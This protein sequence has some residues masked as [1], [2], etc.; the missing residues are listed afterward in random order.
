M[1]HPIVDG[2]AFC[3]PSLRNSAG[4]EGPEELRRLLQQAMGT[5]YQRAWRAA[6]R[7][8]GDT[9]ALMDL[10]RWWSL[11]SLK[12]SDFHAASHGR[13]EWTSGKDTLVKQFMAPSIAEMSYS[14][15]QLVAEMDY[16]GVQTAVLSRNPYL[17][18]GNDFLTN[19]VHRY[20]DRLL[21]LAHVREWL[22][23][24]ELDT[25]IAT[26]QQAVKQQGMSGIHFFPSSM[27]LYGQDGPWDREELLP[28]WDAVAELK[29]PV[30]LTL[31]PGGE[32]RRVSYFEELK[33]LV[34]WI[35][36]YPDVP[37]V[38]THGLNWRLFMTDD[39]IDLPEE[40]WLP[41]E[42][43]N[44]HLQLMFPIALGGVWEYPMAEVRPTIE[45]CVRRIGADR[46]MWGSAMP[47]VMRY[48]TYKQCI[49]FI[50]RYLDDLGQNEL[51]GI[52]GGTCAK[53]LGISPVQPEL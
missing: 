46:L 14:A 11:E 7:S 15:D 40:V 42:S 36:R 24:S 22:V 37:A 3:F 21:A 32:P 33:T 35:N 12:A 9:D 5:H 28:F 4:Y 19:A 29:V 38:I 34:R 27:S 16:A 48:W 39:G 20:P 50:V 13:F 30:F 51:D 8:T 1:A 31:L 6:D 43:P 47:I 26:I 10:S 2:H 52:M 44:L 53:L 25:S 45:E 41:F 49:E 17:G 18:I 23:E